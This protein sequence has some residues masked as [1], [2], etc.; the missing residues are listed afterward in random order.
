MLHQLFEYLI[1]IILRL[2]TV[3]LVNHLNLVEIKTLDRRRL[4]QFTGATLRRKISPSLTSE[5]CS[6]ET[7]VY[8]IFR[9]D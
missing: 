3:L 7:S 4:S 6:K 1:L 8:P 2:K 5:M 9:S